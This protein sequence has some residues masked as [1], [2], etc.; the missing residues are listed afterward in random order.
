MLF[1]KKE[2][3][4]IHQESLEGP[5]QIMFSPLRTSEP[6]TFSIS[7]DVSEN[8]QIRWSAHVK[9]LLVGG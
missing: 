5:W 3:G 2:S 1:I 9:R 6:K 8:R 4:D 7:E